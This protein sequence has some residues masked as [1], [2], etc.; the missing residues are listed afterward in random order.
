MI[1]LIKF[2]RIDWLRIKKHMWYFFLC[3]IGTGMVA[4]DADT[5]AFFGLVYSLFVSIVLATLPFS[6][7]KREDRGF[8]R[9]L[10]AKA[11]EEVAGHFLFSF[12][13]VLAGFLIGI[14]GIFL[15][16]RIIPGRA[17]ALGTILGGQ[18]GWMA[19][20]LFGGSLVAAGVSDLILS[21]F[22]YEGATALQLIRIIP[23]F[24]FFFVIT[25]VFDKIPFD[26]ALLRNLTPAS[27]WLIFLACLAIYVVMA[28]A[29]SRIDARR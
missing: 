12:L 13:I 7:E 9:M 17:D 25:A 14:F 19:P 27:G 22:R 24:I 16:C 8:M 18:A 11:G 26:G 6:T 20:A 5:S 3:L 2:A 21:I 4:R 15:V 23:A 1:R 29:A 28:F 10:P